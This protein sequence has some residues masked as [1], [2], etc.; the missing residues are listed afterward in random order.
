[1][2]HLG[3]ASDLGLDPGANEGQGRPLENPKFQF[4]NDRLHLVINNFKDFI[5]TIKHFKSNLVT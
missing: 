2:D 5:V 3:P 4:V 1:M